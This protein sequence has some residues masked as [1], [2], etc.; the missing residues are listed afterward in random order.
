MDL[1]TIHTVLRP[2]D[3]GELPLHDDRDAF[4]AGG[5]WLFSEPQRD[6]VRLIDLQSLGWA[7]VTPTED[8]VS[9]AATCTLAALD[10]YAAE[11]SWAAATVVRWSR[12]ASLERTTP[13]T[14]TEN[15]TETPTLRAWRSCRS[16]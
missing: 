14:A 6:L 7:P 5:T 8:G 10:A 13:I 16:P 15:T 4:L 2:A 1:N 3:R 9:L 11:A 12:R